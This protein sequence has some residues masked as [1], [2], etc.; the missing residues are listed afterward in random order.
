MKIK[1]E[2]LPALIKQGKDREV[3]PLLYKK[4]FPL[5]ANY[6]TRNSGRKEDTYDVFQDALMIFYKQVINDT[7]NSKY[8]VFGY[9]YRLSINIWINKIKRDKKIEF[10]EDM[11]DVMQDSIIEDYSNSAYDE[12][13]IKTLFA[14]I[15]EKCIELLTYTIYNDMLMEDIV[16]RMGFSSVDAVKMQHMRCKQKLIKELENNPAIAQKLGIR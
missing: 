3:A 1:E 2:E 16:I 6:I 15:G 5:V 12:N 14:G 4:V 11:Q 10:T 9:I 8:K 13:L 7:F